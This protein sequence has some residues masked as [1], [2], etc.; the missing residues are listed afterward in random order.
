LFDLLVVVAC[1]VSYSLNWFFN[2][3]VGGFAAAAR[4]FRMLLV[5]RVMKSL[6]NMQELID[7]VLQNLPAMVN[8][9]MVLG[10]LLFVYAIMGVQLF[11]GSQTVNQGVSSTFVS[12][13]YL[14]NSCISFRRNYHCA[15][16]S[17]RSQ[18]LFSHSF[19]VP[20]VRLGI[21]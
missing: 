18:I 8:I 2:I 5:F 16:I 7:T 21:L 10:L 1:T 17:R 15:L 4:A 14:V 3:E 13:H 19:V 12:P 11:A 9:S 20:L 6:G